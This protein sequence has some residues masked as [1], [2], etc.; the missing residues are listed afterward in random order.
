[1][2]GLME[3]TNTLMKARETEAVRTAEFRQ[4]L[5]TLLLLLAPLAPHITEELWHSFGSTETIHTRPW[6]SFDEGL[7]QDAIVT[8]V[9][10]IN[11][12]VRDK[13]KAPADASEDEVRA[14]ALA[15]ER[16]QQLLGGR[17]PQKV[18]YVP[19]KLINLVG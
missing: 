19:G 3:F 8:V 17:E 10:Q 16:V 12:K 4:A 1:L 2:A 5:E 9:V 7:T 18:I 15:S 6:P 14:Q 13:L 11:G